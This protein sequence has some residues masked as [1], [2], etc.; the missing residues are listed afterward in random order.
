MGLSLYSIFKAGLLCANAVA[1]LHPKRFLSQYGLSEIDPTISMNSPKNQV[2]GLLQAVR[3][4]KGPLI[5]INILIIVL[6]LLM[7]G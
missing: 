5:I 2:I 7:G 3:Y 1:V 4:L 6:E